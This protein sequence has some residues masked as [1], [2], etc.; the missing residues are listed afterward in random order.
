MM[1]FVFWLAIA[2]VVPA[3][4][5]GAL[6]WPGIWGTGSAL[7]EYLIPLPVAGG[8]LHVPSIVIVS[9][10]LLTQR[11][12]PPLLAGV[13]R[14]LLFAA[15]LAGLMLLLDLHQLYLA[16]TTDAKLHGGIPW[17]GNPIGLFV[18][19]DSLIA[20]FFLSAYGGRWPANAREWLYSFLLIVAAISL[21]GTWSVKQDSR[22]GQPFVYSGS[23]SAQ[24]ANETMYIFTTLPVHTSEF[25][26]AAERFVAQWHPNMNMNTEDVAVL[27]YTSLDAAQKNVDDRAAMT[28]CM[29]EDGTPSQWQSG[30]GDCF[31]D[32]EN[33]SE[34][35]HHLVDR[36]DKKLH[37]D[38]RVF[39]ARI[40][41]CRDA[42]FPQGG[43]GDNRVQTACA[44][45]DEQRDRVLK[46]FGDDP[47]AVEALRALK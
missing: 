39:L 47:R 40:E 2:W 43:L 37:P 45:M 10:I 24:L 6:G 13:A 9:V 23:R 20:Q 4:I 16:A 14:A 27:F 19:T 8:V 17:S 7:F 36:Q 22:H 33:F 26:Q 15:A 44:R 38:V 11:N 18:L 5:A 29:Y 35:F 41:V 31:S 30:A 1:L 32:H 34:R 3:L 42:R 21:H 25:R 12:W 46:Q 28:Y